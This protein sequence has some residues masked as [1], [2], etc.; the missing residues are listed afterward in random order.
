M[1]KED[2][3]YEIIKKLLIIHDKLS[4]PDYDKCSLLFYETNS[5]IWEYDFFKKYYHEQLQKTANHIKSDDYKIN[6]F[7]NYKELTRKIIMNADLNDIKIYYVDDISSN[8]VDTKY[9]YHSYAQFNAVISKFYENTKDT[10]IIPSNQE[11][12]KI[13]KLLFE[14]QKQAMWYKSVPCLEYNDIPNL[15]IYESLMATILD[16]S[17]EKKYSKLVVPSVDLGNF[18]IDNFGIDEIIFKIGRFINSG[19]NLEYIIN[20]YEI[21]AYYNSSIF[22]K[23]I[24]ITSLQK[25]VK[26]LFII[27]RERLQKSFSN[28]AK[29]DIYKIHKIQIKMNRNK[30]I[31][32]LDNRT[33][34]LKPVL[35][36]ILKNAYCG[37]TKSEIINKYNYNNL[38]KLVFDL[39]DYFR[40]SITPTKDKIFTLIK[41]DEITDKYIFNDEFYDV[42]IDI[43][44]M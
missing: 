32:K 21:G 14:A 41:Y 13:E 16:S 29:N 42:D 1:T 9:N 15:C 22:E 3:Y 2:N 38:N 30:E 6:A 23:C 10:D 18:Y 35:I 27:S 7:K 33:I 36:N 17:N 37:K 26:D 12:I 8:I 34:N 31:V 40:G 39:N 20:H 28:N 4:N 19:Y 44:C 5:I 11:L 25:I 43:N 24:L